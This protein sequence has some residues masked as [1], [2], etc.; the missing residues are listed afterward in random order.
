[1]PLVSIATNLFLA[2]CSQWWPVK[3]IWLSIFD[4]SISE[5]LIESISHSNS[6]WWSILKTIISIGSDKE[7]SW[8]SSTN[9][10]S[11]ESDAFEDEPEHEYDDVYDDEESAEKG[12]GSGSDS[13]WNT[14]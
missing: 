6:H 4:E 1:M 9:I 7:Y 14:Y 3:D 13:D 5:I 8:D 11:R 2:L 10:E 12:S